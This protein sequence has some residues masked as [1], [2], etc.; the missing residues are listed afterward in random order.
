MCVLL[1]S[2]GCVCVCVGGHESFFPAKAGVCVCVCVW[3]HYA[4]TRADAGVCVCVCVGALVKWPR[5]CR[6]G[7]GGV[8]GKSVDIGGRRSIDK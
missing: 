8:W 4:K 1:M 3:V 6:D 5:S 7:S 2:R